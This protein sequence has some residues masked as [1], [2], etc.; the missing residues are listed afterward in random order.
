M[1]PVRALGWLARRVSPKARRQRRQAKYP[2]GVPPVRQRLA[3]FARQLPGAPARLRKRLR[4]RRQ[5]KYPLGRPPL[6]RRMAGFLLFWRGRRRQARPPF[7]Y[8]I[9]PPA[10]RPDP[11]DTR[12][13][14]P[15]STPR[16]APQTRFQ[17]PFTPAG[18]HMPTG[19]TAG[20]TTP[21]AEAGEEAAKTFT[22]YQP[23]NLTDIGQIFPDTAAF[24]RGL[25]GSVSH[26]AT[27]LGDETPLHPSLVEAI[28]EAVG[29][30]A[31]L[32]DHFEELHGQ[33]RA[34]HADDLER[35]EEP[36]TGET[37]ADYAANQG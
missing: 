13:P 15:A 2:L 8:W 14:R 17:A 1:R 32:G 29:V 35:I 3:A 34:A 21:I 23:E 12:M 11:D 37:M 10:P 7:Q 27:H 18:G 6:H 20:G 19:T 36:R 31:G 28:Q 4:A 22:S 30:M 26:L 9:H 24:F 33:F 5:G 16:P 25:A